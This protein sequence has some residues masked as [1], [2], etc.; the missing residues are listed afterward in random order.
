MTCG[1][2]CR[3]RCREWSHAVR[4]ITKQPTHEVEASQL[5][6]CVRSEWT[7]M[8]SIDSLPFPLSLSLALFVR[9]SSDVRYSRFSQQRRYLR[10]LAPLV[11]QRQHHHLQSP[12][13]IAIWNRHH[14]S[15]FSSS[16]PIRL[17]HLP[18]SLLHSRATDANGQAH[19]SVSCLFHVGCFKHRRRERVDTFG[20]GRASE[21][22]G[23]TICQH[24]ACTSTA[25]Y[26]PWSNRPA[27]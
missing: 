22:P 6:R 5:L 1:V 13:G 24:T 12:S 25:L 17:T 23:H 15:I 11:L 4:Q 2:L 18:T 10:P 16:I 7:R 20:G 8:L 19:C 21:L 27:L 26:S 14:A 3:W 9:S